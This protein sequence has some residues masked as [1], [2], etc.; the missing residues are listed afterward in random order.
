MTGAETEKLWEKNKKKTNVWVLSRK[1]RRW[2][3]GISI[4]SVLSFKISIEAAAQN[5]L[6]I[7][8]DVS[9]VFSGLYT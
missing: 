2:K 6:R 3:V 7:C 8:A 5:N 9:V 4:T 1:C